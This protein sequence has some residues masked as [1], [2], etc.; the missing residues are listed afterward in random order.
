MRKLSILPIALIFT[1][2]IMVTILVVI[3]ILKC[4]YIH[5]DNFSINHM[6]VAYF[7]T[8]TWTTEWV[9]YTWWDGLDDTQPISTDWTFQQIIDLYCRRVTE[10]QE[11]IPSFANIIQDSH[12]GI[13]Y[14]LLADLNEKEK[15]LDIMDPSS[16]I[17]VKFIHVNYSFTQLREW[18]LL[19]RQ[20]F[21]NSSSP[22]YQGETLEQELG[23]DVVGWGITMNATILFDLNIWTR[24]EGARLTQDQKDNLLLHHVYLFTDH[25]LTK[26]AIPW[27]AVWFQ[28]VHPILLLDNSIIN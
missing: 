24:C 15:V 17:I 11:Q 8:R 26:Y 14:I 21:A 20:L 3:P 5:N 22:L 23:V 27:D 13:I 4:H 2:A 25:I 9:D 6:R 18:Q 1:L 16:R 28:E 19:I 12:H 10:N 7:K